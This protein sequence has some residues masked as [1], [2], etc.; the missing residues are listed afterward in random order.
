MG[1]HIPLVT[2]PPSSSKKHSTSAP[3]IPFIF[4]GAI[5]LFC[6]IDIIFGANADIQRHDQDI[7]NITHILL[8][9]R[10]NP[11]DIPSGRPLFD[12]P[13]R[14]VG[15]V[16]YGEPIFTC[17]QP[18]HVALTFDDGPSEWTAFVL[19]ELDRHG[20]KA[21]FFV[22]GHAGGRGRRVDDPRS[23][24]P[25]LVR[26]M[27]GA[28]HQVGSHTWTHAR[29]DQVDHARLLN[30]MVYNEMALRN[31]LGLVP[32]YMRPPHGAWQDP[33]R[34]ALGELG[35]H[36]VMFDVDTQDYLND[37]RDAIQA[38]IDIVDAAVRP[39][40]EGAYIVRMQDVREWTA[41]KL[42]PAVL[43]TMTLR[44]YKPVTVGECL[45]DEWFNWY[46][47]PEPDHM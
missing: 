15:P 39:G 46:R 30:E 6:V 22:T 31:V 36:I 40:G 11:P 43:Q 3:F 17:A 18:G 23:E 12:L 29:L 28:G 13:R 4:M 34:G 9:P 19:D 14:H 21:T 2:E 47:D 37:E 33:A 26:R 7:G 24:W 27:H 8:G 20:A 1:V 35:Y 42:L 5:F 38:S 44:G 16:P 41:L 25:D 45:G 32:T 10:T